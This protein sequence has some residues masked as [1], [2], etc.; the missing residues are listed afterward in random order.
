MD[1][2]EVTLT[3]KPV[4][5]CGYIF[6]ELH[7]LENRQTV[8][9]K[10]AITGYIVSRINIAPDICPKCNKHIKGITYYEN[11]FKREEMI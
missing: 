9:Y 6:D 2:N 5:T 11:I 8:N 7:I 10:S 1:N 3:L 4:C